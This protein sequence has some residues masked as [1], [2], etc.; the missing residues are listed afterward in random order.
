MFNA[1]PEEEKKALIQK[2]EQ[3]SNQNAGVRDK[4]VHVQLKEDMYIDVL[5]AAATA[6]N[7]PER[8]M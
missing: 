1:L 4:T 6:K 8:V 7:V 5:S 3:Q 2:L